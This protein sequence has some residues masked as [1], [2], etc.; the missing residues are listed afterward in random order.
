MNRSI[1]GLSITDNNDCNLFSS[2]ERLVEEAANFLALMHLLTT[3]FIEILPGTYK[4]KPKTKSNSNNFEGLFTFIIFLFI[5]ILL[6]TRS[7]NRRGG[8]RGNGHF[9]SR[10]LF[11]TIILSSM[12]RSGGSF[13]SS[14]GGSFGGGG[15]G[16]FGGGGGFSGG[17][18]GGSW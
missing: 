13:G 14:S 18:A 17:G 5:L 6:F 12:G 16:G 8:G 15:F 7:N 11:N 4:G 10:D 2:F 9:D 3:A 1:F